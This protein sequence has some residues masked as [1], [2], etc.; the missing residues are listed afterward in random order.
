MHG[1]HTFDKNLKFI[2]T[3]LFLLQINL[4][5]QQQS[6]EELV[7]FIQATRRVAKHLKRQVIDD[8][9]DSF[10]GNRRLLGTCHWNVK[11][12]QELPER[13]LVHNVH[14]RHLDNQEIQDTASCGHCG[15]EGQNENS[16][17]IILQYYSKLS[18]FASVLWIEEV[19]Q[20]ISATKAPT[21]SNSK[22]Y[23]SHWMAWSPS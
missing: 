2:V 11:Q 10:G 8:V 21:G 5:S 1:L 16:S 14:V 20:L 3:N 6:E 9:L 22:Q 13:G 7:F 12:T 18:K 4:Q 15:G 23:H 19:W 17:S